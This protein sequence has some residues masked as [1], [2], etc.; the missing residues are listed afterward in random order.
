MIFAIYLNFQQQ[1]TLKNQYLPHLSSENY[2]INYIKSHSP[3]AFQ[4]HQEHT[5]ILIFF[6]DDL[7]F[8]EKMGQ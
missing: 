7:F 4:Q 5:P 2:G 6:S 8:I 1:N 3:R